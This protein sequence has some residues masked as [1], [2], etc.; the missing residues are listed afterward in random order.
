MLFFSYVRIGKCPHTFRAL[1]GLFW[2]SNFQFSSVSENLD[3]PNWELTKITNLSK[4]P[5]QISGRFP[6]MLSWLRVMKPDPKTIFQAF[7][8]FNYEFCLWESNICNICR[9]KGPHTWLEANV[10]KRLIFRQYRT[11]SGRIKAEATD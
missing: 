6:I 3:G 10:S 1:T 2:L 9:R 8:T 5:V 11:K 7:R 4:Q